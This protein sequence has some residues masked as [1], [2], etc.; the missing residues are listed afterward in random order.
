MLALISNEVTLYTL[1]GAINSLFIVEL[2][3][4]VPGS[5]STTIDYRPTIHSN[6]ALAPAPAFGVG[7]FRSHVVC[8]RTD[9]IQYSRARL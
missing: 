9:S 4:H 8:T 6:V 7:L 5:S 2:Y 3:V 1:E